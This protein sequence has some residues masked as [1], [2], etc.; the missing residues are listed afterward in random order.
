MKNFKFLS[1][2]KSSF[3]TLSNHLTLR[4]NLPHADNEYCLQ[5]DDDEPFVFARGNNDLTITINPTTDGNI[6]FSH[7]GR[8]FKL[9]AREANN[10]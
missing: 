10:D 9:F 7:E 2:E 5:F 3:L 8:R 6:I 1:D 4:P